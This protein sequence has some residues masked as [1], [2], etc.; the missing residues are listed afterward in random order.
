MLLKIHRNLPSGMAKFNQNLLF[1]YINIS[2]AA[3]ILNPIPPHQRI[4]YNNYFNKL[5]MGFWGF[6]S[7]HASCFSNIGRKRASPQKRGYL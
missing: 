2:R 6:E 5:V 1:P 4:P 7:W 3:N